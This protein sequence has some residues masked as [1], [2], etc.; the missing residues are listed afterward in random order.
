M[1]FTDGELMK[2]SNN[3]VLPNIISDLSVKPDSRIGEVLRQPIRNIDTVIQVINRDGSV[4]QTIEGKAISGNISIDATS[5]TRRTGSLTLAVDKDYLPKSGGIAWFDKQ[6]KLY[7][8]IIDMGSYNKEPIN[9]LLGT[10]VITNENLSINTTNSTITFTLE[11]KMSLYENATTAYRV[12]I[13][14]GQKIDSAIRSVME[15]MGETVFGKMH[16]SSEQ[17]VVQYDY[18][19]E[20]G[21]NKLDIITDLR[22]M[23]M[24]YTCGFNVRG[25]FE[26][27]KIDVQKEDEVT[28]A[29]WD[30]DP[31]GADRSDLMVSFSED[32]NFKGLY[33]HIVVF[34]GTS[35]K[36]RYT[37]YAE[38]GLT[39]PSVPYNIDAI[40]MR[41]KV[42][43]NNDLSDDI[44]CV[45][46]AKYHLWQTAHLQ[47]TCDITTVPIYVLDGKDI[48][49]IVNPV[50][51][52]KNRYIIDKIGIDFGVDGIMTINT[53]KLHYVR[54]SYG[55]VE[56]PFVKTIKNGI[57]KLGWLSLGEQR[58]KDCYG[59]SGS[60]KN[61]I[62][63]RFFSEEEGGEQAYV[64]G[65][66]TTKVQTL[67]IDIRD[68]RNIIKN[69]QNGEVPN[70]S[71]GDYLDRVLAHEMFH[72][73]CNDYYGFDKAADMPQW[74]KEGFAEFIHG[75][76][77]R[78]Q[79]LDYDSFAQKKKALVDRAELQLKGA[80]GQKNGSQTIA[81]SEDYT[82]AFLLAA[83]IW[84]L[85]GKDGIKKMFEGLHGEGN[86]WSIFPVKILE[87]GGY[88]EVPKNQEDR[89]ND[90]AIQI[91]INTLNNWNDIWNWLQDSQDHDTVSVGGIHFNNLYD[92]ALDA[93]DVFNEGEAKTDSIGF[94]IEYEY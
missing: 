6:F 77:E 66:P 39:D 10:F 46:E 73:V 48:I 91:I 40:G 16:E 94:K 52:E 44:Q 88:L 58:I 50:T 72:G 92:K 35:S 2:G 62:R 60:G 55:D 14:R 42:V 51:K 21:T 45:S 93:D 70:R 31:T 5:L 75:G 57:D 1:D 76:R 80:W 9:F 54:T 38:V 19:K 43:Q 53:H 67:G 56:S 25:E 83:T 17:E 64:Q 86:L 82:S 78:Y 23:Y 4:Y 61:I 27:T 8:S 47:E 63:V 12:K 49:T 36:T 3:H 87:L 18:I 7:Q 22:D 28:P 29:K 30:F 26:F 33:N 79:S 71:R 13:P 90:R 69:S 11:D 81:V 59:I 15:E 41:T 32:Y 34:G 24:D 89:N 74:F 20:I 68:F 65:Y 84:K 85:V 37:P